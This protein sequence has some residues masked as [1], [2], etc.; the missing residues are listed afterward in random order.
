MVDIT[1]DDYSRGMS[2]TGLGQYPKR[3][4]PF[5]P[6]DSILL[7]R[8]GWSS[9]GDDLLLVNAVR[10]DLENLCESIWEHRYGCRR[11][12]AATDEP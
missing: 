1:I 12:A 7:S 8:F 3:P 5:D 9:S 4:D 11:R 10:L 6:P 2:Q